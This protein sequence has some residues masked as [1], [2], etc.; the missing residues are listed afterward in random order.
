MTNKNSTKEMYSQ[1]FLKSKQIDAVIFTPLCYSW[2]QTGDNKWITELAPLHL[3][4]HL[5]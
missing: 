3:Q 2:L 4:K 1:V 5:S